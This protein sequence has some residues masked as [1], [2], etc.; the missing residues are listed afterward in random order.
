MKIYLLDDHQ[1]NLGKS[2]QTK[3]LNSK[4]NLNIISLNRKI[5]IETSGLINLKSKNRLNLINNSTEHL[6]LI[7]RN[8]KIYLNSSIIEIMNLR[9][10]DPTKEGTTYPDIYQLC[11]CTNG[12]LFKDSADGHCITDR[13]I[14]SST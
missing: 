14:C 5:K 6:Q 4:L 13:S 10:F 9:I 1:L 7:S 3:K 12:K 2:I 11:L 8:G